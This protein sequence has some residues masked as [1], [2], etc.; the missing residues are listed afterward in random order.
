MLLII[1]YG[2][3]LR[4]DDGAGVIL[5]ENLE[6]QCRRR[7][8]AAELL[9]CHQLSPELVLEMIRPGIAGVVF[10]DTRIATRDTGAE[11]A[12]E[13][14]TTRGDHH[15]GGHHL[16]PQTLLLLAEKLYGRRLPA[17][18]ITVPGIT[19]DHGGLFSP[20]TRQALDRASVRLQE[21]LDSLAGSAREQP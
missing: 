5:G 8:M 15:A 13:S 4:G 3:T 19:F 12:I 16:C 21:F 1:A 6:Q 20:I 9:V 14:L 18:Q 7:A 2:N 11:I 10:T 17:W